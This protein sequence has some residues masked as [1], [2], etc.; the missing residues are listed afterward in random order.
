MYDSIQ[1]WLGEKLGSV[2]EGTEIEKPWNWY[3]L[4]TYTFVK[5]LPKDRNVLT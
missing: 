3:A 2:T 1:G 4:N 5:Q